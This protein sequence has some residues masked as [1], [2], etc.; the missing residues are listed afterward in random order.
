MSRH[1]ERACDDS[2]GS[3]QHPHLG[4]EG[5]PED[6]RL[7]ASA[8]RGTTRPG[9]TRPGVPQPSLRLGVRGDPPVTLLWRTGG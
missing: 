1:R 4:G 6:Q 5:E 7:V 8:G 2:A 3:P 9:L